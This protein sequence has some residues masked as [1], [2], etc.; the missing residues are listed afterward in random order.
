[1]DYVFECYSYT[2]P[3][4]ITFASTHLTYHDLT[5]WNRDMSEWR[6]NRDPHIATWSAMKRMMRKKYV[7]PHFHCDLQKRF[8]R[9]TQGS[10][11]VEEYYEEFEHLIN[12]LEIGDSEET[13]M[14]QF[15][16]GLKDRIGRKVERQLYHDLQE[17]LHL[18]VQMK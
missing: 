5:W 8:R 4:K 17:L 11:F 12:I 10:K 15:L 9:L 6:R 1:M 18:Y 14:S 2:K 7:P 13:R 16:D 3:R